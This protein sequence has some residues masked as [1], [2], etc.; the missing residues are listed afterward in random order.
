M[1]TNCCDWPTCRLV[2]LGDRET[3][4][5]GGAGVMIV[6]VAVAVALDCARLWAVTVTGPAGAAAGAV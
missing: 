2:L 6:T 4:T 3:E 1:A 5:E